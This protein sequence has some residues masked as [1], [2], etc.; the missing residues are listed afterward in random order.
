MQYRLRLAREIAIER[1]RVELY[2]ALPAHCVFHWIDRNPVESVDVAQ[3]AEI[4]RVDD[5]A[6][7]DP[8]FQPVRKSQPQGV[9]FLGTTFGDL[10]RA[11][12]AS[13]ISTH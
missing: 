7:K 10:V 8:A 5:V 13:G 6:E 9:I 4:L 11:A 1:F 12:P 3:H 2:A